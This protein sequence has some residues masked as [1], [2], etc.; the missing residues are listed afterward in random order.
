M[1]KNSLKRVLFFKYGKICIYNDTNIKRQPK[2]GPSL[3]LL[4]LGEF[5]DWTLN[6]SIIIVKEEPYS[7]LKILKFIKCVVNNSYKIFKER[8]DGGRCC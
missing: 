3:S 8:D 6:R 1:V 4:L 5:R 7:W 2:Q